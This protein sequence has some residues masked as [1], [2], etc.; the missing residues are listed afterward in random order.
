M[1]KILLLGGITIALG[2]LQGCMPGTGADSAMLNQTRGNPNAQISEAQARQYSR[3]QRL[4]ADE[5]RL[6]NMKRHQTT[7]SIHETTSVV[8]D[9]KSLISSF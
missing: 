5:I 9:V 3:Q 1:K 6:Q 7:D 8:R 4:S 2:M